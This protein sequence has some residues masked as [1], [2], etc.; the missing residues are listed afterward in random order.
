MFMIR[1]EEIYVHGRKGRNT[2]PIG[3]EENNVH[4]RREREICF[5]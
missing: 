5:Q 1:K 4:K 2:L 3:Q